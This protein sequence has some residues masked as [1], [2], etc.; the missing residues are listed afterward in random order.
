MLKLL[1]RVHI[2]SIVSI[3]IGSAALALTGCGGAV[4]AE[5]LAAGGEPLVCSGNLTPDGTV[6]FSPWT[7]AG[8]HNQVVSAYPTNSYS[9][10]TNHWVADVTNLPHALGSPHYEVYGEYYDT[11]TPTNYADCVATT[12]EV[13]IEGHWAGS[14]PQNDWYA[15]KNTTTAHGTWILYPFH[16]CIFPS[17]SSGELGCDD[18]YSCTSDY[19]RIQVSVKAYTTVNGNVVYKRAQASVYAR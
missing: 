5:D 8:S 9:S 10:C 2:L 18:I 6:A 4:P 3:L 12:A 17:V 1:N 13:E 19:D 15:L 11:T 7:P 16:A 14:L